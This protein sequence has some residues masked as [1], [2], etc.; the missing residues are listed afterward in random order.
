[1][2]EAEGTEFAR[3][4]TER[5]RLQDEHR[6]LREE[7][8]AARAF[9]QSGAGFSREASE[10][11]ARLMS[12]GIFD[13]RKMGRR[14]RFV[15]SSYLIRRD[16]PEA[17][18]VAEALTVISSRLD[19]VVRASPQV[20]RALGELEAR[21]QTVRADLGANRGEMEAVR[22]ADDRLT[23]LTDEVSRRALVVGRISP[24]FGE[25]SAA[26]R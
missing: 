16:F 12:L 14:V 10:Q 15:S 7:I 13:G 1:M 2:I 8:A 5:V 24:L 23:E 21:L 3:L 11:R 22:S 19:T 9:A 25:P 4:G 20:E 26:V 17:S 6:R 18:E